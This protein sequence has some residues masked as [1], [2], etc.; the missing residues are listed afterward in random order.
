MV[1][2]SFIAGECFLEASMK[3]PK[4]IGHCDQLGQLLKRGIVD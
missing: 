1:A 3:C 4:Q 2:V